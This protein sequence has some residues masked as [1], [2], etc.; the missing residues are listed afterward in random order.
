MKKKLIY[1]FSIIVLFFVLISCAS[2]VE[3]PTFTE[4][5]G[6]SLKYEMRTKNT[7]MLLIEDNKD[8][9]PFSF[10]VTKSKKNVTDG[11]SNKQKQILLYQYHIK[12]D[13]NGIDKYPILAKFDS[14]PSLKRK[15][16]FIY[17]SH[18]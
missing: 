5:D 12:Y 9:I 15:K 6:L 13:R 18:R 2:M 7:G 10:T 4:T 17:N 3:K 1:K 11:K 8:S 16:L 14:L